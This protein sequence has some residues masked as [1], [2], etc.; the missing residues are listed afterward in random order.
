MGTPQHNTQYRLT[1][2]FTPEMRDRQARG[3]NPYSKSSDDSDDDGP[4]MVGN[5]GGIDSDS[6]AERERKGEAMSVLDSPDTLMA[7]ALANN[8]SVTGQRLRWMRQL[9]GIEEKPPAEA[10]SPGPA[11]NKNRH[12]SDRSGR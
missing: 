4:M 7:H 11:R 10:K 3:K 6:F 2:V 1:E 12:T 9:C 5:R 8:D